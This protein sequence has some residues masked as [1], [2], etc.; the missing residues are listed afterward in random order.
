[1]HMPLQVSLS[2]MLGRKRARCEDDDPSSR[3]QANMRDI[4]AENLLPATRAAE[5]LRDAAA[6]NPEAP[7]VLR[8]RGTPSGSN[9][10]RDLSRAY[11]RGSIWPEPYAC[12]I[13]T[14]NPRTEEE[15]W[16]NIFLALPHEYVYCIQQHGSLDKLSDLSGCDPLTLQHLRSCE[17]AA[18]TSFIPLGL[19]GD[20]VPI[21][22]ERAESI[23]TLSMNFVGHSGAYRNLRLPLVTIA[24]KHIS[25]NT[26]S[27]ISEVLAWSFRQATLGVWP[28]R[29]HDGS[30]FTKA[31]RLTR[32]GWQGRHIRRDVVVRAI[33]VE[34]RMDW[35]YYSSVFGMHA[36]NL[37][38]GN[39]W[40]CRHTPAQVCPMTLDLRVTAMPAGH[41]ADGLHLHASACLHLPA[42]ICLLASTFLHALHNPQ[43]M[44]VGAAAAWR[45]QSKS[46]G[47][48]LLDIR[49]RGKSM[50][51]LLQLPYFPFLC[52][53]GWTGFM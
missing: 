17:A 21:Q 13:R 12:T 31:D 32:K 37:Q 25:D 35:K 3:M 11:M 36:H 6:L 18:D 20:G 26:W 4:F 27:D 44:E 33:L 19:W 7:R 29:R 42:C 10:A 5:I 43:A 30:C 40:R 28:T 49:N 47:D 39:C 14:R 2:I 22:W 16:S 15:E 50:N 52:V 46:H 38:I 51:A 8:A 53:V 41:H 23:E 24:S 34:M 45:S 48:C 1:M 9:D